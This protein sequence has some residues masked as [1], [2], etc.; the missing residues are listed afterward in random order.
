MQRRKTLLNG[1]SNANIASKEIIKKMLIDL[2]FSESVR[3]ESLTLE[4]FAS[5]SN[6][7]SDF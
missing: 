5:I 1:L 7:L 2:Q 6:Y 4:Q 3:G